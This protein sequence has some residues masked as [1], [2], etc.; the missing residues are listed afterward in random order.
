MFNKKVLTFFSHLISKAL[1]MNA[2]KYA[3]NLIP[4]YITAALNTV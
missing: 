2:A 3:L 4:F 1:K